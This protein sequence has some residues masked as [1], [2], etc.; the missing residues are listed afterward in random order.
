M[1][2]EDRS[3]LDSLDRLKEDGPGERVDLPEVDRCPRD[4]SP[5]MHTGECRFCDYDKEDDDA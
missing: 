1:T 4:G 3:A 2:P 5:L